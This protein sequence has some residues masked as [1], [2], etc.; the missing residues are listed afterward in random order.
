MDLFNKI[1]WEKGKYFLVFSLTLVL[2][3]LIVS[4]YKNEDVPINKKEIITYRGSDVKIIKDFFFSKVNSPFLYNNYE[5]K[6]G[7]TIEK[8]LKNYKIK[9]NE[10]QN[11]IGQYK[12]Y[13][14]LK[15]LLAG[16]KIEI[17]IKKNPTNKEN[18]IIRISVPITKSTTV[19]IKK[20]EEGKIIS[21]KIITKLY[22]RKVLAENVIKK[23]LY[24]SAVNAKVNPE[25]II[26]FARIFGFEIDF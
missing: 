1:R 3:V 14:N 18:S 16:N 8:I 7:D 5:I 23:S 4:H 26:E 21:E 12:K 6:K 22:K 11:I 17:T 24:A 15:Q 2:L 13:V 25:T 19:E 9:N 20:N 10:I